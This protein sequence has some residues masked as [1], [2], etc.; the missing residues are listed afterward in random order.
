[1]SVS[2]DKLRALI[3]ESVNAVAEE[4]ARKQESASADRPT[5]IDHFCECPDCFCG[6]MDRMNKT[7]DYSCSDCGLPLGNEAF[8]KQIKKCPNCGSERAP[9]KIER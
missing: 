2:E 7:S 9:K 3:R 5:N 6:L 4:R 8:V 1:M